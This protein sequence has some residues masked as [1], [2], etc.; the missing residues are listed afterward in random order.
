MIKNTLLTAAVKSLGSVFTGKKCYERD[1]VEVCRLSQ[2]RMHGQ[3]GL[4]NH[5][6]FMKYVTSIFIKRYNT[7]NMCLSIIFHTIVISI[8]A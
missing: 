6:G 4:L 8:I 3:N 7:K 5:K 2:T 1:I